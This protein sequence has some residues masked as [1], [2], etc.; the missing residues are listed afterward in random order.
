MM[1][2]QS[3]IIKLSTFVYNFEYGN[4]GN[5]TGDTAIHQYGGDCRDLLPQEQRMAQS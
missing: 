1:S 4:K 5:T 3:F 2:R